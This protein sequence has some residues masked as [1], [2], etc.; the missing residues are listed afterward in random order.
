MTA[1]ER[2]IADLEQNPKRWMVTGAAGFIGSHLCE[3]LLR[4]QQEVIAVDNFATG[5]PKNITLL[6]QTLGVDERKRFVFVEADVNDD[7]LIGDA[8]QRVDYVLHQAA[9]GS[10]PRSIEDP[11]ASNIAN[12]DGFLR[13]L[14]IAQSHSV[15]RFVYASSSSVYGDSEGLPKVEAVLG[16]LLS[17]YAVTKRVNELY[18]WVFED[19]YGIETV[20]LRYFNVFGPR[21]DPQGAYAAVIP[22]W[23]DALRRG[24]QCLIYGDGETSRDFCYIDNVVQANILAATAKGEG[25]TKRSYNIALGDRTSLNELYHSIQN[26]LVKLHPEYVAREPLYEEF[27]AGDIRHSLADISDAQKLLGFAPTVPAQEGIAKTVAWFVG[28]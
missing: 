22:K 20:G 18:A 13:I 9:L 25:V 8:M 6:Q 28:K 7:S 14:R 10:V 2:T 4:H 19:C 16:N 21:Q 3:F 26:E 23:V 11:V 27:R 24:E 15:Q 12:V 5:Y 1:F 17:P